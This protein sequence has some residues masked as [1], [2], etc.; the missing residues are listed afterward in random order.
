MQVASAPYAV[1][2]ADRYLVL[3]RSKQQIQELD[4]IPEQHVSFHTAM[5]D[6]SFESPNRHDTWTNCAS[7]SAFSTS[8]P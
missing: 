5:S 6:V 2:T 7:N 8:T 3:V 1:P 4:R